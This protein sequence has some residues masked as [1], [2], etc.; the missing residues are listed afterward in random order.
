MDKARITFNVWVIAPFFV[1][2]I[3]LLLFIMSTL[4]GDLF[5]FSFFFS[6][7]LG[8]PVLFHL[9]STNP[10]RKKNLFHAQ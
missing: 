8:Y 3:A 1:Y 9:N 10:Q 4:Y 2:L 6:K 7:F 5:Y